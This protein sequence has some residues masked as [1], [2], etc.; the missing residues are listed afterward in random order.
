MRFGVFLGLLAGLVLVPL[1]VLPMPPRLLPEVAGP[2]PPPPRESFCLSLTY[3][4]AMN[5]H[6]DMPTYLVLSTKPSA[7]YGGKMSFAARGD[8]DPLW[9]HARWWYAGQDSVDIT[10]HHQ[11]ILRLPR[12]STGGAGRGLPYHDGT[13]LLVLLGTPLPDFKVLSQPRTCSGS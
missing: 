1:F 10:A 12:P 2:T 8:G 7:P 11:P 9:H 13:I 3:S 6:L 4:G 5:Q